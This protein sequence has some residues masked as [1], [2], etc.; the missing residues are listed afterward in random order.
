MKL[1]NSYSKHVCILLVVIFL[2]ACHSA[3]DVTKVPAMSE[4]VANVLLQK[5]FVITSDMAYPMNTIG[6]QSIANSGLIPQGSTFSQF[7]LIGNYNHFKVLGDSISVDLPYFGEQQ[8][9]GTRYNSIDMGIQFDGIPLES[10]LDGMGKKGSRI[11]KFTFKDGIETYRA[12][13]E[14]YTDGTTNMFVTSSHRTSIRY[15]GILDKEPKKETQNE[16]Q[17]KV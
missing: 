17:K 11:Y 1:V 10:Q 2:A 14:I 16:E 12:K 4:K 6:M 8:M 5:E 9:G 15:R 7:S 13:I 3:K